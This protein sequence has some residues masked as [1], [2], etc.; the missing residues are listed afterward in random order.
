[1]YILAVDQARHGA[2]SVFEYESKKLIAYGEFSFDEKKYTFLKAVLGIEALISDVIN[3]YNVSAV[4][5]EGIQLRQNVK[6]FQRLAQLQ[7]VLVNLFEKN[8]YLY[9]VIAPSQWQNFCMARG[10]SIKEIKSNLKEINSTTKKKSKVLS[11]QAVKTLYGIDTEN[12]NLADAILI[13]HYVVNNV[14]I[15]ISKK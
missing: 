6:S 2:W 9:D 3:A 10:R 11:I 1:M 14:P 8:E 13:G 5:I 4:F 15:T 7:G 12:D